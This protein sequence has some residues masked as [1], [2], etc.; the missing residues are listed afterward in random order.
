MAQATQQFTEGESELPPHALWYSLPDFGT[1]IGASATV[2]HPQQFAELES[3]LPPLY[4]TP[5]LFT[6]LKSEPWSLY[7]TQ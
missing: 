2:W 5:Q 6:A 4:S 3:K 7:G 1:R